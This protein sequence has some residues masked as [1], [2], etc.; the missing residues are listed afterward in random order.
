MLKPIRWTS[1]LTFLSLLGTPGILQAQTSPLQA[2]QTALNQE[3]C[4]QNWLA[5]FHQTNAILA[6]PQLPPDYQGQITKLRTQLVELHNSRAVF[7][8][9]PGC[10]G[11]TGAATT[12]STGSRVN[13]NNAQTDLDAGKYDP[14]VN[15]Y[16][17]QR[18]GG[19]S[20]SG[21][22]YSGGSGNCDTPGQTD[23][24]ERR[25]GGRAASVRP[26]GRR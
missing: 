5:A 24:I 16:Y 21:G 17:G 14:G 6:T 13:W 7:S 10:A 26:G 2:Q 25:C 4:A 15:I 1:V 20:S 11:G 3:I 18:Y 12:S 22:S 8:S 9:I 23:S 19:G